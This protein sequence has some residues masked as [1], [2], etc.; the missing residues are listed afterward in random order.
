MPLVCHDTWGPHAK[1]KTD[2]C[3]ENASKIIKKSESESEWQTHSELEK[4]TLVTNNAAFNSCTFYLDCYQMS[5][6]HQE[7]HKQE[8][9][10]GLNEEV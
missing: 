9:E 7:G 6:R 4:Y 1:A 10:V 2:L 8:A 5:G 3:M